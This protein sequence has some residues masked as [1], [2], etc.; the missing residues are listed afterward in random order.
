MVRRAILL[1]ALALGLALPVLAGLSG[2]D[3]GV[4]VATRILI[5]ALAGMSLNLI[6]GYGGMVS[7][8]HAA[9]FGTG[10]YVVAILSQHASL[11]EPL[12]TWPF[13][14]AG[15]ESALIAWPLAMAV[16]GLLALMIG[17]VCLRT[18]G[19]YFIMITLAFAQMIYFFFVS[20]EAYGGDDGLSIWARSTAGP[21]DLADDVQFYYVVLALLL[22]VLA[23]K[24]RLV[25]SRFGATLAGI[26]DNERR[27]AALGFP[28]T[29]Y[30][31][32]AFAMSGALAGLAGA[33][34]A[35][36]TEFV[37]PSF[38]DW[39]RSGEI[40]VVVILGGMGTLYGPIAGA[41]AFLLLE[42]V[43]SQWTQ[44]WMIVMGPLLVLVVI[45]ARRGLWGLVERGEGD[46]G[47]SGG[48]HG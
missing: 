5:F 44:H 36:Q 27:M 8:G 2:L 6:L 12:A 29:R 31:L 14:I 39:Q 25:A 7:F 19:I 41:I 37:S 33:L 45:F 23:L 24:A 13:E 20:L 40:M 4:G 26:R 46:G 3:Y 38:L 18:S 35:N 9:F 48:G 47:P 1:A 28:T 16:A 30:K 11:G 32:A 17:A 15:T 10:A 43:L 42:E 21:L 22:V 34:I